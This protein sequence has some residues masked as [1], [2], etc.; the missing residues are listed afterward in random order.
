MF[1]EYL[2]WS[3][4]I[5]WSPVNSFKANEASPPSCKCLNFTTV[6]LPPFGANSRSDGEKNDSPDFRVYQYS[7]NHIFKRLK[8]TSQSFFSWE[9]KV[10]YS[11]QAT[12]GF[13]GGM[14]CHITKNIKHKCISRLIHLKKFKFHGKWM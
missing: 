4:F 6:P 7:W 2:W 12:M 11:K 14:V 13:P 3:K 5:M 8:T 10:F 1:S 9:I